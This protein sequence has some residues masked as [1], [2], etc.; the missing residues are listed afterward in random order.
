ME[1]KGVM[2]SVEGDSGDE[3][4]RRRRRMNSYIQEGNFFSLFLSIFFFG[5]GSGRG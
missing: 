2:G 1:G 4:R 3:G 5:G